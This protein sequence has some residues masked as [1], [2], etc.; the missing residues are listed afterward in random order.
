MHGI[1]VPTAAKRATG[2]VGALVAACA[3]EPRQVTCTSSSFNSETFAHH[4]FYESLNRKEEVIG[5]CVASGEEE[6]EDEAR[7]VPRSARSV[8]ECLGCLGYYAEFSIALASARD[9]QGKK[10]RYK[11]LMFCSSWPAIMMLGGR[12][13]CIA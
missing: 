1:P 11:C 3:V 13:N 10:L 7:G 6:G 4:Q 2:S 8:G 9:T 12:G 5:G